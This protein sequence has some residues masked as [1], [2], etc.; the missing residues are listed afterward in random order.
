MRFTN[1]LPAEVS[2]V[3]KAV[4]A[5]MILLSH[6]QLTLVVAAT[7]VVIGEVETWVVAGAVVATGEVKYLVNKLFEVW[8]SCRI[9]KV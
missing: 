5:A 9:A 6:R 8:K 7:V 4:V 1:W 3:A 2:L